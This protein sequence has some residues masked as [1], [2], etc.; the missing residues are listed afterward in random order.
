MIR[1]MKCDRNFFMTICIEAGER[2]DYKGFVQETTKP[3][4]PAEPID[5]PSE[6]RDERHA[7]RDEQEK[8]AYYYDDAHGYETYQPEDDGPEPD[9]STSAHGEKS[10]S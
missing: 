8:H 1:A 9:E 10:P 3:E 6:K 7:W 5:D 4:K 2:F